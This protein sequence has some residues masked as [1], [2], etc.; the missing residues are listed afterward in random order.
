MSKLSPPENFDFTR[1]AAWPAWKTRFQRYRVATKL[2]TESGE[3]QVATLVY[4]LGSEADNIFQSFSFPTPTNEGEDPANDFGTVLKMFEDYFVPKRN[5]IHERAKFHQTTQSPSQ[6]IELFLRDLYGKA[7]YCSFHN[8]DESIRDQFVIGLVDKNISKRLQLEPDLSLQKAI[9]IAR[10]YE[11]VDDQIETQKKMNIDY[12]QTSRFQTNRSRGKQN[13]Q[14]FSSG[15]DYRSRPQSGLQN[16]RGGAQYSLSRGGSQQRQYG[17]SPQQCRRCN[18]VHR[19]KDRCPALGL[20]C[21]FCK[22]LN[23]FEAACMLKKRRIN[24]I[25]EQIDDLHTDEDFD[26]DGQFFLH[27]IE[28]NDEPWRTRLSVNDQEFSFKMDT[29]ADVTVISKKQF[30][31]FQQKPVLSAS[32]IKLNSPGGPIVC[33]GGFWGKIVHK[34]KA[35]E[36][37][38]YVIDSDCENLLGRKAISSL[39][40]LKR[41]DS[42]D[43]DGLF[44]TITETPIHC[45]P[46]KIALKKNNEPYNLSTPRRIPIPLMEKVKNELNRM[47]SLGVIEMINEPTDWCAPMVP[48]VKKDGSIRICT[49]FKMLNKFLKRERF[50]IPTFEDMLTKLSGTKVYTKLDLASGFWQIPLDPETAKLTTFITPFGRFFYKRLPFGISSAPEIF[51]RTMSQILKGENHV[52]YIDDVLIF[53]EDEESHQIHVNDTLRD[54]QEAGVKLKEEKCVFKK[55]QMNFLGYTISANGVKPDKEKVN[56]ISNLQVPKDVPEL[57]RVLGMIQYLGR[58][59]PNLTETLNPLHRLLVKEN[60][61]VWGPQQDDAFMRV[62]KLIT[63]APT[64]QFYNPNK[65][66]TVSA[67]ASSYG[68]GAVLL[69]ENED[70]NLRPVAYASRTMNHAERRY[71]QLEKEFL[72]ITWACERFERYLV[73]LDH[74]KVLTDHKPLVPIINKKDIPDAPIRCQRMLIRLMRFNLTVSHTAG[75]NLIVADA[76]SRSP[77][78]NIEEEDEDVQAHLNAVK[79]TWPASDQFLK[80]IREETE[81][82]MV[83]KTVL[84]YVREGWPEFKTNVKLAARNL[85]PIRG[86][87]SHWEGLLLKGDLIVIP[88]SLREEVLEK[89]H[90]GHQGVT[91]CKERA[92]QAVWWQGISTDICSRISS[93]QICI[94]RAPA[95]RREPLLTSDVPE[96]PY[97]KVGTDLFETNGKHYIVT[98]DY[99]SKNID[100]EKIPSQS[101]AAV[102]EKLKKCFSQHGIPE[103]VISDNGPCFSSTEFKQFATEWNFTHTTSSPRYPQ[104]NGQAESAVKIAKNI[105]AQTEPHLALL[106]YRATPVQSTGVSPAELSIGRK[107]RTELPVLPTKLL[108]KTEDYSIIK[109]NIIRNKS[110]QKMNFDRHHSAQNLPEIFPGDSVR[111]RINENSDWALPGRI[112]QK[113]ATRSYLVETPRGLLRRNRIHLKK[114][115]PPQPWKPQPTQWYSYSV[116]PPALSTASSVIDRP[117]PSTSSTNEPMS[118]SPMAVVPASPSPQPSNSGTVSPPQGSPTPPAARDTRV[119]RFGRPINPPTRLEDYYT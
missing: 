72:A 61:W 43:R 45:E 19:D 119:S 82:D 8:K 73:G 33:L 11:T 12:M 64:L 25:T 53:S 5:I 117:M 78:P 9:E 93:C 20:Q 58:H 60:A 91:K 98:V 56:A 74:F 80:R 105:L 51:Q 84:D 76:L 62:K 99:Y 106:A 49:D 27:A 116:P 7:E 44:G 14:Q 55:S 16:S 77:L 112:Q 57:R 109:N 4:T 54:L 6:S 94:Q 118:A 65:T 21:N 87:L 29:G 38:V 66:T 46:V 42:L 63:E 95:Q 69:Q 32:K 35:I 79:S 101:T 104:A 41:I 22:K 89:I 102:I 96:R 113:I 52:C 18:N 68:L 110:Q 13:W 47:E 88:L 111:V 30:E 10:N 37:R 17:Y 86:E 107:L 108:P 92:R 50:V 31:N 71:A 97:Q 40:L 67:D 48:V 70:G 15:Q 90:T 36:E 85:F 26:G 34:Q 81:K 100:I 59:I 23:H 3:V 2:N 1:P 83:L 24:E 28:T 114:V 103:T 115:N 39:G 75:K